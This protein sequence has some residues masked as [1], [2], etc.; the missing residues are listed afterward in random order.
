MLIGFIRSVLDRYFPYPKSLLDHK[1]PFTFLIAVMLSARC[2]D[3]KVNQITPLLFAKASNAKEMADLPLSIIKE[4]IHPCGLP[5][6]KSKAILEASLIIHYKYK[7]MVPQT[8]EGLESLPGVGHKT[9][10]VLMVQAFN[11]P[12]FPVD[13]H[14]YRLARRWGLSGHKSIKKVEEDLKKLIPPESWHNVHLQ[15][16]EAGRSFCPS[17]GHIIEKCP[18]CSVLAQEI[19]PSGSKSP[20][21]RKKVSPRQKQSS[22][23][24]KVK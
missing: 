20:K 4:I 19:L 22:P 8:F 2:T 23:S 15:M 11:K 12:A 13:T 3:K 21:A 9:A 18:I 1:D 6:A 10:S 5:A 14:I 16:I 24:Q 7:G 17:R